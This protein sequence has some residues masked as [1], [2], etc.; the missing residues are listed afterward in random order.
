MPLRLIDQYCL[1]C[2]NIV[3]VSKLIPDKAEDGCQC[4]STNWYLAWTMA[5]TG[6]CCQSIYHPLNQVMICSAVLFD[7]SIFDRR[8]TMIDHPRSYLSTCL[9]INTAH[10]LLESNINICQ[11]VVAPG[12]VVDGIR[13]SA[14][15]YWEYVYIIYLIT[16]LIL[17]TGWEMFFTLKVNR[18]IE[19]KIIYVISV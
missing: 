19:A 18:F 2:T 5:A 16:I 9:L 12:T 17:L 8:F 14:D 10:S 15:W 13:T 7:I 4:W 11:P 6:A 1:L 3:N